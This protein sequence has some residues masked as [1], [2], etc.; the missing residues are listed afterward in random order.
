MPQCSDVCRYQARHILTESEAVAAETGMWQCPGGCTVRS[1]IDQGK[2]AALEEAIGSAA[3]LLGV[4]GCRIHLPTCELYRRDPG[5]PETI[6]ARRRAL[7][8]YVTSSSMTNDFQFFHQI[9]HEAVHT[10]MPLRKSD[11]F[12][13][14]M[15]CWHSVYLICSG[16]PP[17]YR[18]CQERYLR[19]RN[20]SDMPEPGFSAAFRLAHDLVTSFERGG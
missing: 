19:G 11:W 12:A 9:G 16:M 14:S 17:G 8:V 5:P 2:L 1:V 13:E 6:L 7:E 20:R 4:R 15:A 3:N 18:A 10:F